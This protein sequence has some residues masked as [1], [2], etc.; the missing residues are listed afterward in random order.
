M[1]PLKIILCL[2]SFTFAS[3]IVLGLALNNYKVLDNPKYWPML[4]LVL[5]FFLSLNGWFWF[6][7]KP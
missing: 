6:K 4:D 2:I 7:S 1:L 3:L 5:L